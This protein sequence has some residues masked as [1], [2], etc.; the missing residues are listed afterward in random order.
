MRIKAFRLIGT[1]WLLSVRL[2]YE[3]VKNNSFYHYPNNSVGLNDCN[4][5][6]PFAILSATITRLKFHDLWRANSPP[7]KDQNKT[8]STLVAIT[9]SSPAFARRPLRVWVPLPLW[10]PESLP[11]TLE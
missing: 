5:I 7:N 9:K 8:L 2:G 10:P 1:I 11:Q 6:W 3:V 4:P